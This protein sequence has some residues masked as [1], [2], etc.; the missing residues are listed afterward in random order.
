MLRLGAH[1]LTDKFLYGSDTD[2]D[3]RTLWWHMPL[4]ELATEGDKYYS[5]VQLDDIISTMHYH[6]EVVLLNDISAVTGDITRG[7]EQV[8]GHFDTRSVNDSS[9]R[10]LIFTC[11]AHDLNILG[12]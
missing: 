6:D 11:A 8:I 10:L 1:Y 5:Y 2:K 3:T 7:C 12:C 9:F 4:T